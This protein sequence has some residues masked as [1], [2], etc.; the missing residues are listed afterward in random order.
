M[1]DSITLDGYQLN[2]TNEYG[3]WEVVTPLEG[4]WTTP[5]VKGETVDRANADGEFDLPVFNAARLITINGTF[6]GETVGAFH[7]GLNK[8]A[9][10]VQSGPAQFTVEGYGPTQAA[11]VKRNGSELSV[12]V[13]DYAQWQLRL[14]AVDPRKFGPERR[15]PILVSPETVQTQDT[16]TV[17][18]YGNYSGFVVAEMR[19]DFPGGYRL[20]GPNGKEFRVTAPLV[21][22]QV[23]RVDFSEGILQIDGAYTSGFVPVADV[24][25][26]PH[27]TDV[28]IQLEPLTTGTGSADLFVRDTYI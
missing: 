28:S 26:I 3:K 18:Q 24:W 11:T 16:A 8:L 1:A 25:A 13:P 5:A 14:K 7:R 19:G 10:L 17:R 6:R 22:G 15:Y 2:G 4:W 27:D 21:P 9:S 12:P 20:I 23:H